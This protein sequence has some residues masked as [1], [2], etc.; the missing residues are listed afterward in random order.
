MPMP[1]A[2]IDAGQTTAAQR[3]ALGLHSP[4]TPHRALPASRFPYA[5]LIRQLVS[6]GNL[7]GARRL[8]A[9]ARSAVDADKDL[10]DLQ[11]VLEPPRVSVRAGRD[12]ER[13]RE[14]RWLSAYGRDYA[15]QWVALD[16]DRLLA[17][18]ARLADVLATIEASGVAHPLLMHLD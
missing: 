4:Y 5:V 10:L 18:G 12:R 2:R 16:G 6:D 3:S 7:A 13:D 11:R 1:A 15:G 9:A 8:L 14:Y 17:S